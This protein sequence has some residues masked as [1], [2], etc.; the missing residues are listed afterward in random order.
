MKDG[1]NLTHLK[2]MEVWSRQGQ[3]ACDQSTFDVAADFGGK[4]GGV[5]ASAHAM[6]LNLLI[7]D[8]P[9]FHSHMLSQIFILIVGQV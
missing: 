1:G 8:T 9:G 2:R 4:R 7:N 3:L 6:P 5:I